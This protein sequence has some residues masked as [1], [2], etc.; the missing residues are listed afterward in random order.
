MN[1][2]AHARTPTAF[3][4]PAQGC[5]ARA[6]LGNRRR[7]FTTPTG[8]RPFARIPQCGCGQNPVGVQG[9]VGWLTQGSL[10]RRAA[11]ATLG[12]G[13]ERRWRSSPPDEILKALGQLEAEIQQG[14][15]ELEGM[16]K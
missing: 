8:L 7:K 13:T 1:R 2:R 12:F 16:L 11:A 15:K 10:R 9:F 3:R 5:E 14:M 6:T 4:P